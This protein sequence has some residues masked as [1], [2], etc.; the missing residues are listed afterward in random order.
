[1]ADY[2]IRY[3]DA[4]ADRQLK[5]QALAR[6]HL[7]STGDESELFVGGSDTPIGRAVV[8]PVVPRGGH[9]VRRLFQ[10]GSMGQ[11]NTWTDVGAVAQDGSGITLSPKPHNAAG[12]DIV[13]TGYVMPYELA[14]GGVMEIEA[15]GTYKLG[16]ILPRILARLKIGGSYVA[17]QYEAHMNLTGDVAVPSDVAGTIAN[18]F[19]WSSQTLG[20][21]ALGGYEALNVAAAGLVQ[22]QFHWRLTMKVH[23]LGR[24]AKWHV[25]DDDAADWSG[26]SVAYVAG[27]RVTDARGIVWRCT[28][29]HTSGASTEPGVGASHLTVW[30][31]ASANC[32]VEATLEWGALQH[33]AGGRIGE[34]FGYYNPQGQ[35]TLQYN[36]F[37]QRDTGTPANGTVRGAI[38]SF[39]GSQWLCHAASNTGALIV[40]ATAWADSTDY[41]FDDI[42]SHG[43]AN[44]RCVMGH[45][46]VLV[47]NEPGVGTDW[48]LVWQRVYYNAKVADQMLAEEAPGIGAHW[49]EFW[50]PAVSKATISGFASVDWTTGNEVQLELGGPQQV[51][52]GTTFSAY[53]A[54]TAYI[55]EVGICSDGGNNYAAK[56]TL[57]AATFPRMVSGSAVSLFTAA[58]TAAGGDRCWRLLPTT[59]RDEMRMQELHGYVYG[60]RNGVAQRRTW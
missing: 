3:S 48:E 37:V 38:Y 55:G 13:S 60:R 45:T 57:Y 59:L 30:T 44:Y 42:R 46:S 50:V 21:N 35:R 6:G 27:S 22:G 41:L 17:P 52:L 32:W 54:T 28:S 49:K 25:G 43:G 36:A 20:L 39:M 34:P 53:G 56:T 24:W 51:D 14:D 11:Q 23:A 15:V 40:G 47:D 7:G 18:A 33:N 8:P 12:T 26:A 4:A 19:E 2:E 5:L 29:N 31:L 1:M 58:P 16:S 10:V 9:D